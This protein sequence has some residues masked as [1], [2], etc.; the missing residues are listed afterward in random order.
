MKN[1]NAATKI[2][3]ELSHAVKATDD[4]VKIT[5]TAK[6]YGSEEP[7]PFITQQ[8]VAPTANETV[9]EN[10]EV[11]TEQTDKPESTDSAQPTEM[12]EVDREIS[13]NTGDIRSLEEILKHGKAELKRL[14]LVRKGENSGDH[15]TVGGEKVNAR[16]L[17]KVCRRN[18]WR[19]VCDE[20]KPEPAPE[21]QIFTEG[22]DGFFQL[23]MDNRFIRQYSST[24]HIT[25]KANES[26]RRPLDPTQVRLP[27]RIPNDS[28]TVM[29][30]FFDQYD[31]VVI[32]PKFM[33]TV[34]SMCITELWGKKTK[35]DFYTGM[36]QTINTRVCLD[37]HHGMYKPQKQLDSGTLRRRREANAGPNAGTNSSTNEAMTNSS[38]KTE[39]FRSPRGPAKHTRAFILPNTSVSRPV[40]ASSRPVTS[41]SRP[42][43]SCNAV[44]SL[45]K[46]SL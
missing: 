38:V 40:T 4:D 44:R 29:V 1:N 7:T 25:T 8:M 43:T 16:V 41:S 9:V 13:H 37:S 20:E 14:G 26:L 33:E 3:K 32:Q 24:G 6:S 34:G 17:E 31:P 5:Q 22:G 27:T 11:L 15:I 36:R 18:Q 30:R 45:T 23:N 46:A 10:A 12:S 2:T 35:T 28:T 21:H 39:V 19:K 42:A